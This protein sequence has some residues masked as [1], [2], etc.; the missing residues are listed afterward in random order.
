MRISTNTKKSLE[1]QIGHDSAKEIFD[2]LIG[3]MQEVE[4]L[5]RNK[6]NVTKI[7]KGVDDNV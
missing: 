5:K 6:V 1:N 2:I 4:S 7:I 3:L